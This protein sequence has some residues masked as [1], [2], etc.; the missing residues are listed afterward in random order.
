MA[1]A[2]RI[3]SAKCDFPLH[4][5]VT[6]AGFGEYAVIKSAVGIGSLLLDGIGDT[7]RVSLTGDPVLEVKAAKDILQAVGLRRF[8]VEIISCP[9]CARTKV[10]LERLAREVEERCA[11]LNRNIKI[12]VM[13][14]AVNGPGE[15][16]H[17]DIGVTAG[18]GAGIIYR[19]G[20]I[21]KKV[22]ESEIFAA[23]MEEINELE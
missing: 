1:E 12:A 19:K 6:E 3:I 11:G 17:S 10:N 7:I 15:A 21:V 22:R 5:G 23:V 13:G 16:A 2:V 4:L 9:T 18:D 20:R 14:C 8:G